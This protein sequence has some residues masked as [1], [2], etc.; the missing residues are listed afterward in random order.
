MSTVADF[1][2]GDRGVTYKNRINLTLLT[3]AMT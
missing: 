1:L 3:D 2:E